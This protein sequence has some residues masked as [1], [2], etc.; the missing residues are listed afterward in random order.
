MLSIIIGFI[1]SIIAIVII[2]SIACYFWYRQ[3]KRK[4]EVT[5]IRANPGH[6]LQQQVQLQTEMTQIVTSSSQRRTSLSTACDINSNN[7][8]Q[9]AQLIDLA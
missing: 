2:L 3:A 5:Y 7:T 6:I 8:T 4:Q 9:S 1:I